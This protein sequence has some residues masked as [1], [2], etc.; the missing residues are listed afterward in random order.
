MESTCAEPVTHVDHKGYAYCTRHGVQ[1]RAGGIRCRKLTAA[2]VKR[3]SAGLPLIR[4]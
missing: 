1:R 3:L 4:Y 2:E